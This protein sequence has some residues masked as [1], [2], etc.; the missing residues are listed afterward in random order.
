MRE[1]GTRGSRL[2]KILR[3]NDR[4]EIKKDTGCW[5]NLPI[6]SG[7]WPSCDGFVVRW[8][9][10]CSWC[11]PTP[12]ECFLNTIPGPLRRLYW[13]RISRGGALVTTSL[14]SGTEKRKGSGSGWAGLQALE[15]NILTSKRETSAP[16]KLESLRPLGASGVSASSVRLV[17][18]FV[19]ALL[20]LPCFVVFL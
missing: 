13:T 14:Q 9:G 2:V 6:P 16:G 1:A 17:G 18:T 10:N 19:S 7:L 8:V 5:R 12:G 3:Q 4:N 11:S 15:S 20:P